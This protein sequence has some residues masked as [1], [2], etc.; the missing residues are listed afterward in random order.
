MERGVIGARTIG[1]RVLRGPAIGTIRH[2]VRAVYTTVVKMLIRAVPGQVVRWPALLPA[3]VRTVGDRHL[4]Q[5]AGPALLALGGPADIGARWRFRWSVSYQEELSLA[6]LLQGNRITDGWIRDHVLFGGTLPEGGAIIVTAHHAN[7][8]LGS[9]AFKGA[10][11]RIGMINAA[12]PSDTWQ[13]DLWRK[14]FGDHI[15]SASAP[16]RR[17][18]TA[19][20]AL[21]FLQDGGYLAIAGDGSD[22]A[23][24]DGVVLGRVVRIP[25]GISWLSQ[26]SGRPIVPIML[27]PDGQRWRLW[28]GEPVAPTAESVAAGVEQ[29]VRRAPASWPMVCWK[30]WHRA[31]SAASK[32]RGSRE[33]ALDTTIRS[34]GASRMEPHRARGE[35]TRSGHG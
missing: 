3:L 1:R 2:G 21:R 16:D 19:R 9:M 15:F 6:L 13:R 30:A 26:R 25:P 5:V 4:R 11:G 34:P 14:V 28:C 18:V 20:R 29:C 31:P 22:R 17:A 33:G 27:V 7:S 10:V 35:A 23:W 12:P 24:P 8:L 32:A